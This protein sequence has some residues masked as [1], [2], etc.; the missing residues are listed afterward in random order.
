ME[1]DYWLVYSISLS[2]RDKISSKVCTESTKYS[3]LFN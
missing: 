1:G 2:Y 3:L